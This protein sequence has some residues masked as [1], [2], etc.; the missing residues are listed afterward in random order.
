MIN[1]RI[2][3]SDQLGHPRPSVVVRRVE[4]GS[5]VMSLSS[6]NTVYIDHNFEKKDNMRLVAEKQPIKGAD[7]KMYRKKDYDLEHRSEKYV[8]QRTVSRSDGRWT[9]RLQV[10]ANE[11]Y[12]VH[13][14]KKGA[15]KPQTKV[16][17]V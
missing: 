6:D 3:K 5:T 15:F 10:T 11:T 7:I 8:V 17:K 9:K 16:I 14:S 2:L 1:L 4:L 13:F 12:V